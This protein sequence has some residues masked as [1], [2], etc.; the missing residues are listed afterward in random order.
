VAVEAPAVG[1]EQRGGEATGGESGEAARGAPGAGAELGFEGGAEGRE[2][3]Q[4]DEGEPAAMEVGPDGGEGDE[5]PDAAGGVV[6]VVFDEPE[7]GSKED[8]GPKMRTGQEVDRGGGEADEGQGD[9]DK[10][11]GAAPEHV[12]EGDGKEEAG[13]DDGEPDYAFEAEGGM[14]GGK[15]AVREPLPG[16]PGLAKVME[17]EEILVDEGAGAEDVV[18]G[19]DVPA[20]IPIGDQSTRHI[21]REAE[22]P[23]G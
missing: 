11:V 18:A 14:E 12:A 5:I 21:A 20:G 23:K 22:E 16:E 7:G 4:G 8:Q 17:R 1:G 10:E 6:L 9:G 19:A 15:D 3:E 13:E 2:A